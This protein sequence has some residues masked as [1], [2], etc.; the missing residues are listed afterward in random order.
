MKPYVFTTAVAVATCLFF[1]SYCSGLYVNYF[2]SDCR[3]NGTAACDEAVNGI[4]KKWPCNAQIYLQ[5]ENKECSMASC[6]TGHSFCPSKNECIVDNVVD[7]IVITD[8]DCFFWSVNFRWL[9]KSLYCSALV[10]FCSNWPVSGGSSSKLVSPSFNSGSGWFWFKTIGSFGFIVETGHH[11][12]FDNY[13][14]VAST[15]IP[16]KRFW[17]IYKSN[18]C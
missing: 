14:Y 9:Y 6:P 18:P 1:V 10:G 7:N 12:F 2:N 15:A 3:C 8:R 11:N 16:Y 5:C 4:V 13:N 17:C